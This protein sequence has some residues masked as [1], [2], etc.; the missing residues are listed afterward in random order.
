[1]T[2]TKVF[3][4]SYKL[5]SNQCWHSQGPKY[6]IWTV[7]QPGDTSEIE[8]SSHYLCCVQTLTFAYVNESLLC[9][10]QQI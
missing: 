6:G 1:M 7:L 4:I 3:E 8:I 10:W 5:S 2:E 9:R